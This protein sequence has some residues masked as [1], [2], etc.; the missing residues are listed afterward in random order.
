M[1]APR[2]LIRLR[3]P[4]PDAYATPRSRMLIDSAMLLL[5]QTSPTP[6]RATVNMNGA[7]LGSPQQQ[8]QAQAAALLM[9]P[10]PVLAQMMRQSLEQTAAQAAEGADSLLGLSTGDDV[11]MSDG[12]VGN[13]VMVGA[14]AAALALLNMRRAAP[15]NYY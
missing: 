11:E 7:A 9:S 15:E 12:S 1:F 6:M 4:S 5:L 14:A 2:G 13:T 3:A 10:F 8:M